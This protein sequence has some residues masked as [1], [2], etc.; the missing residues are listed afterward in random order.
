MTL[1]LIERFFLV[2]Q[3][4]KYKL[5]DFILEVY[6]DYAVFYVRGENPYI[7]IEVSK[8]ERILLGKYI[9]KIERHTVES[10][11]YYLYNVLKEYMKSLNLL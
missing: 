5:D 10:G 8:I 9:I 6:P 4:K 1:A 2:R 11:L 7:L 3:Y